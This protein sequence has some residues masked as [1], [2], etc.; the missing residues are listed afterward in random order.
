MTKLQALSKS[1][2][3]PDVQTTALYNLAAFTDPKLVT[4]TLD[5]LSDG[6]VRNQDSWILYTLLLRHAETREQAPDGVR[7]RRTGS[8][9]RRS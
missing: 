8:R 5:Y 4:R 3:N 7:P 2:S 9:R 6:G 1:A